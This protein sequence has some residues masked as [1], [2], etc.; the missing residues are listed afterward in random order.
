MYSPL[1]FHSYLKPATLPQVPKKYNEVQNLGPFS[2]DLDVTQ[3]IFHRIPL[4]R[5]IEGNF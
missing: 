5:T 2:I 1:T 3:L 4:K